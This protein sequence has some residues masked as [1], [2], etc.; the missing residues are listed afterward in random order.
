MLSGVVIDDGRI[1]A[2]RTRTTSVPKP[3]MGRLRLMRHRTDI[4]RGP[5]DGTH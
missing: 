4:V 5:F 1:T 3:P 2:S